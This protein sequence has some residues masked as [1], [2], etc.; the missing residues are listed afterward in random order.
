LQL[1][2]SPLGSI[3]QHVASEAHEPVGVPPLLVLPELELVL[4]ELEL[5]LPELLLVLELELHSVEQLELTQE[6]M[7]VAAVMQLDCM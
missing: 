2:C 3:P 7:L 4:P 5:V 6:P 1:G